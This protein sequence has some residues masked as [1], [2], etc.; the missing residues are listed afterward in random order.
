MPEPD[1]F[2]PYINCEQSPD[3]TPKIFACHPDASAV[4]P[5]REPGS[6]ANLFA[7]VEDGVGERGIRGSDRI[8]SS[9]VLKYLPMTSAPPPG[10]RFALR[11]AG[12]FLFLLGACFLF[13]SRVFAHPASGIVVD[14]HGRVYFLY[15]G[16]VRVELSGQLS[17]IDENS[18]GHWLTLVANGTVPP[19]SL[20]PY[21]KVLA[22]GDTFLYGDGAPLA[23]GADGGLYYGSNG[24]SAENFPAGALALAMIAPGG[25][26]TL[27]SPALQ[28]RLAQLGDGIT[29]LATGSDGFLYVATWKGFAKLKPDG[30]IAKF[31]YPLVVNDCDRDPADHNPANAA[32]PFFRGIAADSDGNVYLAATSCHRVLKVAQDGTLS[33]I[34]R[35]ERPWTPTG[36]ALRGQDIYVLEYTNANGPRTEGWYPRVRRI[37]KNGLQTLVTVNPVSPGSAR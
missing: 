36:I 29:A 8:Y 22:D 6:P 9:S 20:G 4:G 34:L 12:I 28:T 33:T 31:V 7:G 30:S 24:S 27:F 11:R 26:R 2:R 21:K 25:Q 5:H 16:L 23:I 32:S 35:S 14:D 1:W 13:P 10:S 15:H 18:G 3:L 37:S 17:T 19:G